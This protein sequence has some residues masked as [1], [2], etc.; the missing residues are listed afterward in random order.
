MLR[1]QL[2]ITAFA[3]LLMIPGVVGAQGLDDAGVKKLLE[4]IDERQR[5]S[6]DFKNLVLVQNKEKGRD[7]VVLEAVVYR[8]DKDDKFMLLFLNPKAE[9]GKGYLRIDRNLWLYDPS[10]G[11]WERRTERERIAG[12]DS[13]RADFDESR[14][15]EEFTAEYVG[16]EKLGKFKAHRIK[17]TAKAE[18]DVA[19]PVQELWVDGD[20]ANILKR[21]EFA[22]S[23]KLMRTTY[24][25]KWKKVYSESKKADVWYPSEVR[26]F[27]EVEKGNTTTIVI[28][29]VDLRPLPANI[30][31]KA[32]L[33]GQSR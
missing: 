23:G 7:D 18:V 31:T 17:L 4:T 15:A 29:S 16:Q 3:A 9:R 30:F 25:P 13:R 33:E 26:I 1:N 5:N 24:T 28:Q 22:L 10:V 6:G 20:T 32:W 2:F 14:L 12:T 8:R 11:R 27:D 19:Y 21:Q